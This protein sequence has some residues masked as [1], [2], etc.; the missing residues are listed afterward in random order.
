VIQILRHTPPWV[1]ALFAALLWLGYVQTRTRSVPFAR[2][3]ILPLVLVSLSA[4]GI[5]AA[6]GASPAA[7]GAWA[8][9]AALVAASNSALRLP[10]GAR[11]DPATHRF[12]V[13]GSW[14]PLGVI[15]AI[16]FT[17][18]AVTVTLIMTP[19]LRGAAAFAGAAGFAYGLSSGFFLARALAVRGAARASPA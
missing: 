7:Y 14:W 11:Y 3:A 12:T 13:P 5:F 17:R 2:L 9:G 16:F 1:F 8:L 10:R 19:A 18:Y 4:W 15:L 6:F